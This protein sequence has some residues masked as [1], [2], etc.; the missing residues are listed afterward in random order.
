MASSDRDPKN[1]QLRNALEGEEMALSA[2][3]DEVLDEQ[4]K[5]YFEHAKTRDPRVGAPR[6]GTSF[7]LR[8]DF[9]NAMWLYYFKTDYLLGT[10]PNKMVDNMNKPNVDVMD[11]DILAGTKKKKDRDSINFSQNEPLI[12]PSPNTSP[13]RNII[14]GE[15]DF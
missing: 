2:S 3:V 14:H 8:E 10:D 4:S 1:K 11:I 6:I 12:N 5:S 13:H 9:Y 7:S 15:N